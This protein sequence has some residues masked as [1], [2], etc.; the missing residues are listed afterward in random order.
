MPQYPTIVSPLRS[1]LQGI[2]QLQSGLR[3]F[4]NRFLIKINSPFT[5]FIIQI[6]R[7]QG[8]VSSPLVRYPLIN[9]ICILC[10][11]F[12]NFIKIVFHFLLK[13]IYQLGVNFL[14][15]SP[16]DPEKIISRLLPRISRPNNGIRLILCNFHWKPFQALL[17]LHLF[18][19]ICCLIEL[20]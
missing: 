6:I 16:C 20:V 4:L 17:P 9:L 12:I 7:K 2:P 18:F 10:C 5:T 11:P 1:F 13:L 19:H 14:F 15:R 8:T 3:H